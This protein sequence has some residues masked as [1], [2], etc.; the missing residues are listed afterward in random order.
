MLRRLNIRAR[1]APQRRKAAGE[2]AFAAGMTNGWGRAAS[3]RKKE[4]D[5]L[6]KSS[7]E[8][9]NDQKQERGMATQPHY[10]SL[11]GRRPKRK[12]RF[13]GQT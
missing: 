9:K 2:R 13:K 1:T 5:D 4:S 7:K 6:K 12:R 10:L 3:R 11:T 8:N